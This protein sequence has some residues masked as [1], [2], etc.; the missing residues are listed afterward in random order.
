[1]RN[2]IVDVRA[3]FTEYLFQLATMGYDTK[4]MGVT[5]LT[6]SYIV[7]MPSGN[8]APGTLMGNRLGSTATEALHTLRT[9]TAA[10]KF[11]TTWAVENYERVTR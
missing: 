8:T 10:M 6:S 5:R 4:G 9:A 11:A 1:M 2:T 3:A 7:E